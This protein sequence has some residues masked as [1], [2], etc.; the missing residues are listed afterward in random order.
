MKNLGEIKRAINEHKLFLKERFKVKSISVFGSYLR[1]QQSAESDIDILVEFDGTIDL[2]DFV[3]LENFLS[4]V[5]GSRVDLIMKDTLKPRI[6]N[7]I[8]KEAV[9]I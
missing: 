1:G 8:L 9:N 3:E 2:F 7:R 5:L 6:R 4:D